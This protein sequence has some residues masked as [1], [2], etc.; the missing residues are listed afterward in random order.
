MQV[1]KAYMHAVIAAVALSASLVWM[2][3]AATVGFDEWMAALRDEARTKGISEVTLDAA[4]TGVKP[5]ER[6]V[7]LDRNQPEFKKDFWSYLDLMVN[8]MRIVRGR[9]M[10]FRH[11]DL[12]E[13]IRE[14]YGVQP[15]FLVAIWGLETNFGSNLGGFPVVQSLVTLA[16]DDRRSDFF[17]GELLNALKILDEGHIDVGGMQGSWA[18]AMGQLQ[19][20]PSTFIRFA[21]DENNDGKKDIWQSLPDVFASAAN[22]L[23]GYNWRGDMTWGREV[24]LP[25]G[26]DQQ[27]AGID[28]SMSLSEWRKKGVLRIDGSPLPVFDTEA[29]LVMPSGADGPA[30]LV[31]QN[32]RAIMRWNHSHLY[33]LA[34]C[35]LADRI[36]GGG[37]LKSRG[38]H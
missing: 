7:E 27:L 28:T 1:R 23:A 12:L 21:V 34:V 32:Y 19:F 8:K 18:G 10:L 11:H 9:W 5:V 30:F 26:F 3:H 20:M 14:H 4:L 13:K 38:T 17:R 25:P 22:F 16:Y 2:S 6:V 36:A 15:R 24:R 37:P 35:H 33:A 29:S 31:Y